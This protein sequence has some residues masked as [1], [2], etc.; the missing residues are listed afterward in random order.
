MKGPEAI[1]KTRARLEAEFNTRKAQKLEG[2]KKHR[3]Q[4]QEK[5]KSLSAEIQSLNQKIQET[6]GVTFRCPSLTE[7]ARLAQREASKARQRHNS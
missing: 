7:E 2:M 3:D 5:M 1:A 4:L 6:E